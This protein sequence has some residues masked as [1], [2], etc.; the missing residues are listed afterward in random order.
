[1]NAYEVKTGMN[2]DKISRLMDA[3][4]WMDVNKAMELGFA[5]GILT[6]DLDAE[7]IEVPMVS[8]L[9]SKAAVTNSLMDKIAGKCIIASP[10]VDNSAGDA[11]GGGQTTINEADK[12]SSCNDLRERLNFIKRFI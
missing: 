8:M 7:D 5:D 4:T 2:R 12:G 6:R 9:Y 10:D 3:E 11:D 1:M